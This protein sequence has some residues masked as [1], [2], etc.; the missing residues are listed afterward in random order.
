M[1]SKGGGTVH[2][3]DCIVPIVGKQV[4]KSFAAQNKLFQDAGKNTA[5]HLLF[6]GTSLESIKGI[7][8]N[9]FDIDAVPLGSERSKAMY[10]GHGVNFS[11]SPTIRSRKESG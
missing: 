5:E 9:N 10:L 6:H 3:I 11:E 8:E 7:A 1:V 4:K 2:A